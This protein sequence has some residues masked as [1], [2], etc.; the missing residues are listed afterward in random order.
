LTLVLQHHPVGDFKC[1][2]SLYEAPQVP[3]LTPPLWQS[4]K[5]EAATQAIDARLE[6]IAPF[7]LPG[8]LYPPVMRLLPTEPI[9]APECRQASGEYVVSH[10]RSTNV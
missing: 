3:P 10:R 8:E 7:G 6:E 2:A 4:E 5:T 9:G 1:Q